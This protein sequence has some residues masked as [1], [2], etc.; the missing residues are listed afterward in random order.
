M[1]VK[2]PV[3][4]GGEM[5]AAIGAQYVETLLTDPHSGVLRPAAM[6]VEPVQGEGGTIP[7]LGG[8]VRVMR[9]ITAERRIPLIADEVQTG[10]GRTGTFWAVEH[11]GITPDVMVMSKAIGG[12]L[13]LAV[14]VYRGELD[15]WAPG[16]HTGTFRGNQLAMASG[17]EIVEPGADADPQGGRPRRAGVLMRCA[18]EELC[19]SFFKALFTGH[20]RYLAPLFGRHLAIPEEGS[21]FGP[22]RG[23]RIPAALPR[24]GRS[25]RA[26]RARVRAGVPQP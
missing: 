20:F 17:A 5:G 26:V 22:R 7:A 6:I 2:E 24:A 15:S 9:R 3:G 21:G 14:I 1:E 11:S 18:P 23:A 13:P 19:G 25:V 16:A 12:S 8:W 4:I 10:L